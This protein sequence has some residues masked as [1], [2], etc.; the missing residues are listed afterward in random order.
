M[1]ESDLT[2]RCIDQ[3]PVTVKTGLQMQSIQFF[4]RLFQRELYCNL[5]NV[6]HST[7]MFFT[8]PYIS[9]YTIPLRKLI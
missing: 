2:E 3:S 9:V 1:F 6:S 5:E 4:A 7:S 8:T